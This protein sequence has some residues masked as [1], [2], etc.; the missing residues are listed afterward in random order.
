MVEIHFQAMGCQMMAAL[1]NTSRRGAEVLEQV[2]LWFEAWEQS[3]AAS[4]RTAS[5]AG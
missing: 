4:D 1:D 2:P 5:S 3:S